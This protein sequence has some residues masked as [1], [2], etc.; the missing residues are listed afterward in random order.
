VNLVITPNKLAQEGKAACQRSDYLGAGRAFQAAAEG[1]EAAQDL[2]NAAEMLNNSS[3]AYLQAGDAQEAL[4]KVEKTPAMFAS[5]GDLRRQ[6]MA[7]GNIAA[8]LE[9]LGRVAEAVEAYQQSAEL[10]KQ[11]GDDDS[12]IRVVQSLSSLQLRKGQ[13]LQALVTMQVGLEDVKKP[14]PQ[15]RLLKRLLGIPFQMLRR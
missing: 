1:F 9:A 13:Q 3:V 14:T 10:L 11:A 5:V 15:Q 7:L 2:A 8:A 4:N 12:R 6:G